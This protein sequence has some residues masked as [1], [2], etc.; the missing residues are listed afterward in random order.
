MSSWGWTPETFTAVGTTAAAVVGIAALCV[1]VLRH[2]RDSDDR[3]Q[4]QAHRV[5]VERVDATPEAPTDTAAES[6]SGPATDEPRLDYTCRITNHSEKPIADGAVV[7]TLDGYCEQHDVHAEG[8]RMVTVRHSPFIQ[9]RTYVTVAFTELLEI[10]PGPP[11]EVTVSVRVPRGS[12]ALLHGGLDFTD[13]E[14]VA[15]RQYV[16]ERLRSR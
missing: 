4:R 14:G 9:L 10:E 15:W 7:L 11:V 1:A 16:G 6:V 2:R 3:R 8:A 5:R 12:A 13:G